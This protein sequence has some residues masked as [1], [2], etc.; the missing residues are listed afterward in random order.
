VPVAG[1]DFLANRE[2]NALAERVPCANC[3]IFERRD[4]RGSTL[5]DA[6]AADRRLST[7]AAE[8]LWCSWVASPSLRG[9]AR[10]ND[11]ALVNER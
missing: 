11:A 1:P 3:S 5:L 7:R 9:H 2:R 4:H 8:L 6:L 10:Q